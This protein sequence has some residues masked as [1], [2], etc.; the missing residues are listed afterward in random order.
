MSVPSLAERGSR[1]PEKGLKTQTS[2]LSLKMLGR[3]PRAMA[4]DQPNPM[5]QNGPGPY[6]QS[7]GAGASTTDGCT[8]DTR[9][10]ADAFRKPGTPSDPL[11][12]AEVE[13]ARPGP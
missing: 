12:S 1:G 6:L 11:G 3:A 9:R 2:G 13:E 4:Q 7:K 5:L 8:R 10:R